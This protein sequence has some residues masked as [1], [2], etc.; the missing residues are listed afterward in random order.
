MHSI[1]NKKSP[2]LN[3]YP[4]FCVLALANLVAAA[5]SPIQ[6]CDEVFNYWEPSH[7][8]NHGYGL[9]TWEYSPEYA[10]RSWSYTGMH[11]LVMW[12]GALP[13]RLLSTGREKVVEFYFLRVVLAVTCASCQTRLY[14]VL[15]RTINERVGT[16]FMIIM[17]ISP[18][19]YH[20]SPAY[21]PSSFAMYCT[22]LGIADFMDWSGGDRRRTS[23]GIMWMGIGSILGWPF[24]G[25]LVLPFLAEETISASGRVVQFVMRWFNGATRLLIILALQ[26]A[27]D[28]FFYQ[29][30]VCVPLN[31]VLYNVFSGGSRGPDIYGVEP[32]HFYVRNLA[33]NF[34]IWFFL[35]LGALPLLLLQHLIFQKG[36]PKHTLARSISF[37][38]PF[39]LWLAIFTM[40]P[41]K[42]ERFMYP[43]YPAL[44]MNAAVAL[45]ILLANLGS[46]DPQ[47]LA[48]KIPTQIKTIIVLVPFFLSL[49]TGELRIIGTSWS[50]LLL[51]IVWHRFA[52][53]LLNLFGAEEAHQSYSRHSYCLL[54]SPQRLQ[55]S[56]QPS[57]CP[58]RR[59]GLP[60]QRMVPL[61][62][63]LP[64]PPRRPRQIHQERILRHISHSIRHERRK[65]RRRQ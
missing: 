55:A 52:R 45:H 42:E 46:T 56:A 3:V 39:Y 37:V 35:A 15:R 18:G 64:P 14:S 53:E 25:A 19:M 61:P 8:L 49:I 1:P 40:Q 17:V 11:S 6:D 23:R 34:N 30:L 44:A 47:R 21:L 63:L 51:N 29:K 7:Y 41:H 31:I 62:I 38:S 57:R 22:M 58:Y 13:L 48:S 2:Q 27:T 9:Q 32:W 43:V 10:I 54:S 12:L 20:A 4:A 59:H 65:P 5:F 28:S 26:T 50:S 33:L 24:A 36:V 16:F 60:R